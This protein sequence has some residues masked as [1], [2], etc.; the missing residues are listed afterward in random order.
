MAVA[1]PS[2]AI[3]QSSSRSTERNMNTVSFG[4]GYEQSVPMGINYKRDKW[5]IVW[6]GLTTTERNTIVAFLDV[7]SNGQV[8]S[9]QSPY[10]SGSKNYRLDGEWSIADGGGNIYTIQCSLR[11]VYD[12]S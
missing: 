10:D 1:F 2:I 8:I 3:D 12:P 7:V 4:G 11:Q 9:W 6:T 5:N